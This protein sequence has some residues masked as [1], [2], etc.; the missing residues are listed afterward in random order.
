MASTFCLF[1][2]HTLFLD[3]YTQA[4][5]VLAMFKD[6]LAKWT[7]TI[8][9]KRSVK[10]VPRKHPYNLLATMG[11]IGL[12]PGSGTTASAAIF[13]LGWAI[14]YYFGSLTLLL[15]IVALYFPA[16]KAA[17]WYN[18]ASGTHDSGDIVVDEWVGQW[19]ALLWLPVGWWWALLSFAAFRL[20]DLWKP[21]PAYLFER[22][23]NKPENVILDD[24]IAGL[25]A[26]A[27]IQGIRLWLGA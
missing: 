22:S 10:P 3:H 16:V 23:H 1:F 26:L 11:G 12:M 2:V 4:R 7:K 8:T 19:I 17:E 6:L 18:N 24:V 27:V 5:H 13:P 25:W 20:F 14:Q 21:W 9:R 15:L